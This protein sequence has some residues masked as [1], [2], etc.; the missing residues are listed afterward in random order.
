MK[1]TELYTL[2][3]LTIAIA[4]LFGTVRESA[5]A[6]DVPVLLTFEYERDEDEPPQILQLV[7][8]CAQEVSLGANGMA[9]VL[10][11]CC[12]ITTY[13]TDQQADAIEEEIHKRMKAR[14]AD[15]NE[16]M[17]LHLAGV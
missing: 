13:L 9:L 11:Q 4:D 5:Y 17:R 6:M 2:P 1:T 14:D 10:E 15:D 3:E 16:A 12:D 8:T 7:V